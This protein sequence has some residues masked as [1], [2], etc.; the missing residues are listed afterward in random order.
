MSRLLKGLLLT[1]VHVALVLSVVAKY[2]SDRV[3]L[4]RAWALAAPYDPNLPIRGRYVRLQLL[5]EPRGTLLSQQGR[6]ALSTQDGKLVA[7]FGADGLRI[8]R[9]AGGRI[10]LS[11]PVAFFIPEHVSDPSR[12]PP[13]EELWVEV[14]VPKEGP[15]RPVRLGVKKDG[16]ITPLPLR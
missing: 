8:T 4:P 11:E 1:L 7:T 14:S 16:V 3:S 15:P 2:Y 13:G 6:A 9:L 12:R 5:V 10:A